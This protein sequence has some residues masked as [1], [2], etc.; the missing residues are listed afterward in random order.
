MLREMDCVEEKETNLTVYHK[1]C[2]WMDGVNYF[3]DFYD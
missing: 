3:L 1:Y 2:H